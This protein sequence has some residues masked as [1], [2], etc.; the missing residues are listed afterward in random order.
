MILK[1]YDNAVDAFHH[2]L[3]RTSVRQVAI[4]VELD[5]RLQEWNWSQ[6]F[7]IINIKIKECYWDLVA[8]GIFHDYF[9]VSFASREGLHGEVGRSTHDGASRLDTRAVGSH[10]VINT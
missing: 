1:S 2:G 7:Q 5:F 10:P 3:V 9:N 6:D 4:V 8:A